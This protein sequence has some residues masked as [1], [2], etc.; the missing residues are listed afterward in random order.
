MAVS[1]VIGA[2]IP[3][4]RTNYN[5]GAAKPPMAMQVAGKFV[6]TGEFKT[7]LLLRFTLRSLVKLYPVRLG[8]ACLLL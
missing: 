6:H 8:L 7:V 5:E 1:N 4:T 2:S 3:L